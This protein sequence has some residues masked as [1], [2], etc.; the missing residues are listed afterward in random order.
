MTARAFIRGHP[1][2]Y[3]S[4]WEYGDGVPISEDRACTRC[5]R[6]PVNGHDA[7]LGEIPG[8]T[9]VTSVTSACCWHGKEPGFII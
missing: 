7:C 5:R 4:E 6:M 1:V 3:H 2:V 9:S 8:V